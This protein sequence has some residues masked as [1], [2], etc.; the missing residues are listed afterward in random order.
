M[1]TDQWFPG[2]G[3]KARWA[4]LQKCNRG[5]SEGLE[6]FWIMT[7][8]MDTTPLC[9]HQDRSVNHMSEFYCM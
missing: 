9:I 5:N 8:M 3:V 6:L 7:V 2:G 1:E 4:R